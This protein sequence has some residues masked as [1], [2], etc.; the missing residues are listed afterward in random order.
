M[1]SS[2]QPSFEANFGNSLETILADWVAYEAFRK[3]I[4]NKKDRTIDALDLWLAVKAYE[5]YA[6]NKNVTLQKIS[7]SIHKKFIR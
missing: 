2:K 3:W 7:I 4:M 1:I 6:K 5:Q